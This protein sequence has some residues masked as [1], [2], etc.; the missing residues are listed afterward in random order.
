MSNSLHRNTPILKATDPRGLA[1]R[2]VEYHRQ[3]VTQIPQARVTRQVFGANGFL[4]SQWDPRQCARG[5]GGAASQSNILSLSGEAV[6]TESADA[7]WRLILRGEAGQP[8]HTWDSRQAHQEQ[9]YDRLLRPVAVF[10]QTANEPRPRCVER[11]AYG[12]AEVAG[13]R[14]GRLI[15]HADP[16]GVVLMDEYGIGGNVIKQTRRFRMDT[17]AV[18][19]P[20]SDDNQAEQLETKAHTTTWR[21]DALGALLEQIDA[22][23]NRRHWRYGRQGWLQEVALTLREGTRQVLMNQRVYNAS[24]LVESERL[25]NDVTKVAKYAAEDNRLLQ[26]TVYRKGEAAQPLQDLVYEYDPVGNILSLSDQAQPTQ[27]HSNARIDAVS[28]YQYDSLYQLT[29]ASGRENAAGSGGQAAPGRVA[30]GA[31]D[32]GLWRNYTQHYTWQPDTPAPCG[33]QWRRVYPGHEC[34]GGQQSRLVGH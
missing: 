6:R 19:W 15:R 34:S 21:Y 3:S 20:S 32:D 24:G 29:Q 17:S 5:A 26:L 27:W 9:R 28:R 7:G 33:E 13:N 12:A 8:L 2:T 1:V 31:T 10:E 18:D 16:A 23:G 14:C 22:K 25:G 4:S 11:L 30:F